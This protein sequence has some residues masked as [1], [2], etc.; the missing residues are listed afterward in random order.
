MVYITTA[1]RIKGS[2]K[3]IVTFQKKISIFLWGGG[4][5]PHWGIVEDSSICVQ[6]SDLRRHSLVS[7]LQKDSSLGLADEKL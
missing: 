3:P 4:G 7:H 6:C 5:V 2:E 1:K